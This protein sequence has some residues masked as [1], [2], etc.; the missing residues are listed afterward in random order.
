[1]ILICEF[2][3]C[4]EESSCRYEMVLYREKRIVSLCSAHE[5]NAVAIHAAS[6]WGDRVQVVGNCL[7]ASF[8][9][10]SVKPA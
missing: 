5:N 4:R 6:G 2:P 10:F 1:M 8:D 3:G 7:Q 9:Q